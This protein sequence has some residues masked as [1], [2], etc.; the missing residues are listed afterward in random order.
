MPLDDI[1]V[2]PSIAPQTFNATPMMPHHG[3]MKPHGKAPPCFIARAILVKEDAVFPA[4]VHFTTHRLKTN[5][6]FKAFAGSV[7]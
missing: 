4:F 5:V 7:L 6:P 2:C 3:R 1:A